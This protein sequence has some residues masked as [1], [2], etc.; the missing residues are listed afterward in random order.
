MRD[1]PHTRVNVHKLGPVNALW[2]AWALVYTQI[3]TADAKLLDKLQIALTVAGCDVAEQTATLTD[4]LEETAAGSKVFLV[5]FEVLGEFLD[6][7]SVDSNLNCGTAGI[8]TGR[9][10]AFNSC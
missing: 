10:H 9:L 3:L 5:D 8:F 1:S 6:S 2:H 4:E 7:L